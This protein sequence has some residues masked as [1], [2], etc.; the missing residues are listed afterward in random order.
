MSICTVIVPEATPAASVCANVV[1]TSVLGAAPT[2]VSV[3]VPDVRV[4]DA[5]VRVGVPARVSLYAKL[6]A[7]LPAEMVTLVICVAPL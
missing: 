2:T 4:P 7:L 5:A 1:K 3:C 6:A